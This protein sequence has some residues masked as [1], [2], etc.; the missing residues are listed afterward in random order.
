MIAPG[1][2]RSKDLWPLGDRFS[3][4]RKRKGKRGTADANRAKNPQADYP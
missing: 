4:E 1:G 3:G 2:G